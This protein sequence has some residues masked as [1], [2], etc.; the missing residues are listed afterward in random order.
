MVYSLNAIEPGDEP[1]RRREFRSLT[2]PAGRSSSTWW[3]TTSAGKSSTSPTGERRTSRFD[4]DCCWT[5]GRTAGEPLAVMVNRNCPDTVDPNVRGPRL[6]HRAGHRRRRAR[7]TRSIGGYTYYAPLVF[8]GKGGLNSWLYIQNA[9]IQCTL[10]G[11]LVQGAGQLP[12]A[13][14]GRR[15]DA[16]RRARRSTSTRTRW[17]ARTGSGACGSASSQ[18]LAHGGGHDGPEPLHELHRHPGRRGR[19]ATRCGSSA[20]GRR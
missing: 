6:V 11:A 12:A 10:A 7:G 18:P 17:S 3:A 20:W 14:P 2:W 1:E 4:G 9:G 5:S 19:T 16:W 8:A 13:D 15:A